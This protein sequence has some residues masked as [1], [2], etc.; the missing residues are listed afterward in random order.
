[1][2][3]P[4]SSILGGG[5][6][7]P[8]WEN[9]HIFERGGDDNIV[10]FTDVVQQELVN[11]GPAPLDLAPTGQENT[12]R[13][14]R[15]NILRV[16]AGHSIT[17]FLYGADE[18]VKRVFQ[19]EPNSNVKVFID[20]WESWQTVPIFVSVGAKT[21]N[22][23]PYAWKL[24]NYIPIASSLTGEDIQGSGK[25]QVCSP[26]EEQPPIIRTLGSTSRSPNGESPVSTQT[27]NKKCFCDS[28]RPYLVFANKSSTD[29]IEMLIKIAI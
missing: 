22:N 12:N 11:S 17:S 1:M 3:G 26:I 19:M 13:S 18:H 20:A 23:V 14:F 25:A 5:T 4:N 28:E 6:C 10:Y 16:P 15:R 21:G 8:R 7:N 9:A 24:Y 29:S 27:K 2:P